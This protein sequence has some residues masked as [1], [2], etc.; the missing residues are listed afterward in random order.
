MKDFI[1]ARCRS[2]FRYLISIN[3]DGTEDFIWI[4]SIFMYLSNFKYHAMISDSHITL[5]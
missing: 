1:E 2:L 4:F 3:I 5:Y